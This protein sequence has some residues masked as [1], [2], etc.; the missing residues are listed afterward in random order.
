M[1]Q[2]SPF[3]GTP[4][5]PHSGPAAALY[6]TALP[7][8]G[9]HLWA[10]TAGGRPPARSPTRSCSGVGP[11]PPGNSARSRRCPLSSW[12]SAPL[13]RQ[14]KRAQRGTVTPRA[15]RLSAVLRAAPA[16]LWRSAHCPVL[17][18]LTL[19][20][21]AAF[22]AQATV[23]A[24]ATYAVDALAVAA[25][26]AVAR[27]L[28]ELYSALVAVCNMKFGR[29]H[30]CHQYPHPLGVPTIAQRPQGGTAPQLGV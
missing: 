1:G 9:T 7:R 25:A 27:V 4:A 17:R 20:A 15:Q 13:N 30:W 23:A 6:P 26:R 24:E 12:R 14:E 5:V 28:R 19:H 18:P 21:E 3:S 11:L 8:S 22:P 16:A 29:Y 2:P 10:H